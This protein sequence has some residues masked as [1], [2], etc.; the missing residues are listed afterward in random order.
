MYNLNYNP[1]SS[2]PCFNKI[3]AYEWYNSLCQFRMRKLEMVAMQDLEKYENDA[4]INT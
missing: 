2:F 4:S 1:F 3:H